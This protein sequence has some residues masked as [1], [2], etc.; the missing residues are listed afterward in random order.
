MRVGRYADGHDQQPN[1]PPVPSRHQD[2]IN[3]SHLPLIDLRQ[4]PSRIARVQSLFT[5]TREASMYFPTW[6]VLSFKSEGGC[7]SS[8]LGRPREVPVVP[9]LESEQGP[10]L[11]AVVMP[12][13]E[14]L[15]HQCLYRGR[16]EEPLARHPL[17]R[18]YRQHLLPQRPAKPL[19]DRDPKPLLP[20]PKNGLGQHPTQRPLEQ[21]LR[22]HAPQ[23]QV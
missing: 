6:Q 5:H 10:Q 12:A 20:P 19:G 1:R 22:L 18:Q 8:L 13:L 2:R 7:Q 17:R 14:V 11:L 4:L 16:L 21:E 23:L 15:T 3:D 9:Q